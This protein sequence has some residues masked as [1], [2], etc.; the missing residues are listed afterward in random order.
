MN[1][2]KGPIWCTIFLKLSL[3]LL[4][5]K[6]KSTTMP[7]GGLAIKLRFLT[8]VHVCTSISNKMLDNFSE[9]NTSFSL[10]GWMRMI[11]L[12]FFVFFSMHVIRFDVDVELK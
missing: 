4:S 6:N 2:V 12:I 10:L 7:H 11:F 3:L 1:S 9:L 8:F 5:F